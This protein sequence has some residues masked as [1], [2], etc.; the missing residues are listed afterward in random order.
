MKMPVGICQNIEKA[1]NFRKCWHVPTF[2]YLLPPFW[3]DMFCRRVISYFSVMIKPARNG[4]KCDIEDWGSF[5]DIPIA[6]EENSTMRLMYH[7]SLK[8]TCITFLAKSDFYKL[9]C[10]CVRS[11][12]LGRFWVNP[13]TFYASII[14]VNV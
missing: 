1:L 13:A 11:I 8:L 4:G 6:G 14:C 5:V 12:N 7:V 10:P 2:T 9:L 3:S